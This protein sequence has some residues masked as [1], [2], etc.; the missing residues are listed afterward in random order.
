MVQTT[1]ILDL[2]YEPSFRILKANG[3]LDWLREQLSS[4]TASGP[5]FE[6]VQERIHRNTFS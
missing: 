1:W 2:N 5:V 6:M 4:D 3:T